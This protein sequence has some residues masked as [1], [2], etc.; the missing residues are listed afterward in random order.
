MDKNREELKKTLNPASI[1][2]VAL[3]SIIGWGC[4]V[5]GANWT[6]RAGGP[7]PL[8][9]A[10]IVG[11]MLMIVVGSSYS[12]MI[13]KFPVAGGEFSY[14]YKGFG[15][16]AAYFCGWML[17]LGYISIVALNAT[18]LPLLIDFL[19]PASLEKC[20]LYTIAG[21]DVYLAEALFSC[22]FL[23]IFG[24]MNYKGVETVGFLQLL[25]VLIM[26][27]AVIISSIGTFFSSEITYSH[28]LPLYGVNQSFFSGF[29]SILAITPFLYV[30]FDVIPQAAEEYNFPPHKS[31][32]LINSALVTGALVY[33]AMS[34]ITDVVIPWQEVLEMKDEQGNPITWY[35]GAVLELVMG[36]IGVVCVAIAVSMGVCSGINGFFMTSSRLIFAMARA[37]M[38][39]S[40]FRKVHDSYNTPN[41]CVLF[42]TLIC[43][44]CPFFGREVI[45]WV[46]DMC[47]VG[48]A[49]GYFFTCS[50][51]Y[52]LTKKINSHE[53]EVYLSPRVA[54]IG[55]FISL[56]II[57]L[58]FFPLSPAFMAKESFFALIAW[59]LL[60][61]I[62]FIISKNSFDQVSKEEM[63]FFILGAVQVDDF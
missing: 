44:I 24:L 30:G 59:V 36:R 3:G 58:L 15:R 26:C 49:I 47:S 13:V 54:L 35:T 37:R 41:V 39:P 34:L 51:A 9:L 8:A 40:P 11:C 32:L 61:S 29:I 38:L 46:V 45:N 57:F 27:M 33:L 12:Y 60:G 10:F 17:S 19:F 4:F 7:L 55:C 50:C 42:T 48:T 5:Q 43:C 53:D 31:K 56:F 25:M 28:L 18:A 6:L 16:N 63:D 22:F 20:Y 1:W 14:A 23:L 62:F 52:S 2:A 21:Y